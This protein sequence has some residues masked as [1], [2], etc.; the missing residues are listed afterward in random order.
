MK[1]SDYEKDQCPKCFFCDKKAIAKGEPW[2]TFNGCIAEHID[3]NLNC[4]KFREG[5]N[6]R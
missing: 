2:C 6:D 5:T 4:H 1:L 3:D